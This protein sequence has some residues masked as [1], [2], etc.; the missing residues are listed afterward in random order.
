MRN[1]DFYEF[2]GVIAPGAVVLFGIVIL[3]PRLQALLVSKDL[4]V[5]GFG[6]FVILAY[7][8][9]HVTQAVGNA[10]EAVWWKLWKGMPTDW[11]RTGR[12]SL[13]SELQ[14]TALQGQLGSKLNLQMPA[15]IREMSAKA[16]FSVTRQVYAA[17]AAQ[18]RAGR[19]DTFNGNY[20]LNRGIGSSLLVLSAL[21]VASHYAYWRE[22]LACVAVAAV[23]LTRMHRFGKHYARELFVQFLQLPDPPAAFRR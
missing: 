15:T 9:G 14:V 8:A 16:W 7:V 23:A 2:T 3:Y 19:V 12:G 18:G 22:A 5:G 13:I 10:V 11:V 17:V 20:G 1:F 21:L 4:S 6:L